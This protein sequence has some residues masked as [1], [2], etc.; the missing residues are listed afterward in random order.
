MSKLEFSEKEFVRPDSAITAFWCHETPQIWL[1]YFQGGDREL[2]RLLK[3]ESN[4]N[5]LKLAFLVVF[6]DIPGENLI[7]TVLH[8][9]SLPCYKTKR[10]AKKTVLWKFTKLTLVTNF[11]VNELFPASMCWSNTELVKVF[12]HALVFLRHGLSVYTKSNVT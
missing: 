2:H 7:E 1:W 3:M 6:G 11:K 4:Q 9:I 10:F 8:N 5:K 12:P